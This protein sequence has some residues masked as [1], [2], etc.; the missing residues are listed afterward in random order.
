MIV[1]ININTYILSSTQAESYQLLE[2]LMT[3]TSQESHLRK[4]L[5]FTM[6]FTVTLFVIF[7]ATM[8]MVTKNYKP[9][10]FPP[11]KFS[12]LEKD[13]GEKAYLR[14]NHF[15]RWHFYDLK[16]NYFRTS[17]FAIPWVHPIHV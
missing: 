15:F 16:G 14:H 12:S 2:S 17:K 9:E 5:L 3:K 13:G 7:L 10:K 4:Q 6:L 11:G 1:V 8:W